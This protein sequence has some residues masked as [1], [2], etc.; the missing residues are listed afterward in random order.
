MIAR[1]IPQAAQ[2]LVAKG[3]L[4]MEIS[5][6][7]ETATRRLIAEDGSFHEPRLVKDLAQLPRVLSSQRQG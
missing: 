5:P 3:W 2:R 7:I 1:L 4:I 6:M